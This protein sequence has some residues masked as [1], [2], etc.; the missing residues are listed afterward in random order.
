M[1]KDQ[2]YIATSCRPTISWYNADWEDKK[3]VDKLYKSVSG[4]VTVGCK[5]VINMCRMFR[6]CYKLATLDLSNFD[7][8][9]VTDMSWMFSSCSS[10]AALILSNNDMIINNFNTSKVEDMKGMFHYC[11]N[12][13]SLDLSSFDTSKVKDM[14][15]MFAECSNLTTLDISN[16]DTSNVK[17]MWHMFYDCPKLTTIKG[18]IDM[19]SCTDDNYDGMFKW[20]TKLRDVKIKNPPTDFESKTGLSS[21]QYTVV[22]E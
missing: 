13:T 16:F 15:V 7:T 5:D 18:V 4:R 6:G 9:N 10:L 17:N 20:C 14:E 1:S 19:K 12:L 2:V 22:N 3:K 8:S 11:S 21:S